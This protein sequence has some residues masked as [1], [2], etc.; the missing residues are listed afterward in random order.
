M[1]RNGREGY[2]REGGMLQGRRDAIG[3][4]AVKRDAACVSVSRKLSMVT[5]LA[6]LGQSQQEMLGQQGTSPA[7]FP[8]S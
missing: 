2:C 8:C 6:V 3:K 1:G 4:D 5:S 7:G